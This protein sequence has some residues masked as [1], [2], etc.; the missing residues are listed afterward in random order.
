VCA[1]RLDAMNSDIPSDQLIH[2]ANKVSEAVKE[3]V[4]KGKLYLFEYPTKALSVSEIKRQVKKLQNEKGVKIDLVTVDYLDILKPARFTGDK[5][6]DQSSLGEELRGM[7]TVLKLPVLTASQVNRNGSNKALI[8]GKDI[9][10][11]WEKIMVADEIITLSA[12]E[13]ELANSQ[14]RIHFSESRNSGLCT[15]NIKTAFERGRFYQD[16]ITDDY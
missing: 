13:D 15:L 4:P 1:A 10:G 2:R 9:A 8:T 11:S 14:L 3:G 7:A 5:L 12:T 6:E 16:F